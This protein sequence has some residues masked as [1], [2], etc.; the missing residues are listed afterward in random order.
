MANLPKNYFILALLILIF[1]L[2]G[3]SLPRTSN[4]QTDLQPLEAL[5]PTLAPLGAESNELPATEATS[6]P[7]VINVQATATTSPLEPGEGAPSPAEPAQPTSAPPSVAVTPA[8][9]NS[10]AG[11]AAETFVPAPEES[12]AAAE[13]VVV[14]ATVSEAPP[15]APVA[16]NPP[17]SGTVEDFNN[18]AGG[19]E[20]TVQPGDT[21]F[22]I[23][24]RYGTTAEVIMAANGLNSDLVYAGQVLTIPGGDGAAYPAPPAGSAPL[25]NPGSH[26][27]APGDTLFGIAM[28]YGTT[29]EAIAGA[30]GIPY[31]FVI[32]DGQTL[33]V[34][35]PDAYVAPPQAGYYPP[36]APE[37]GYYPYPPQG[38]AEDYY[39]PRPGMGGTHTVAPGETLF[40]IARRYG[41]TMEAMA[42]ANGLMNPNQIYVGQVLY[43]P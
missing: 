15:D 18:P 25:A 29:V 42:G 8:A 10:Q 28:R 12:A 20:Y 26:V 5:P 41:T 31:P 14:D 24:L 35:G 3:C 7:T 39:G 36:Q 11:E 43:L 33:T 4:E 6:V 37:G 19:A 34:P 38:P 32:Y 27:V 9:S 40:S 30:N 17:G 16:A 13:P 1:G 22:A 21:L 23:G 2:T